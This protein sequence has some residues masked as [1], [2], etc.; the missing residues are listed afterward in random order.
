MPDVNNLG[1][2]TIGSNIN[3]HAHHVGQRLRQENIDVAN[4][5]I[6]LFEEKK[7]REE[8]VREKE[9]TSVV[10]PQADTEFD[11]LRMDYI[12]NKFPATTN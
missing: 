10:P 9:S 6:R 8:Q 7:R 5:N 2:L 4:D 1:H 11:F 12:T 3:P